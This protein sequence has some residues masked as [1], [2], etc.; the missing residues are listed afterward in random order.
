MGT[1][2]KIGIVG[3]RNFKDENKFN[4]IMKKVMKIITKDKSD[5]KIT[6]ISGGASGT[7]TLAYNWAKKNKYTTKIHEA[8][9]KKFGKSAGPKRNTLIVRDS[10]YLIAFLH[11]DSVGTR[12]SIKKAEEKNIQVFIY[13]ISD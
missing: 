3:Y 6:V 9:W 7:D 4:L 12:D 13:E 8:D 5:Y 10:D 2:I 1:E 11:P